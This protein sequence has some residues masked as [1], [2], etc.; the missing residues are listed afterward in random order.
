VIA[1][2]GE[3]ISSTRIRNGEIDADGRILEEG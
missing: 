1:E 2:D 3:R